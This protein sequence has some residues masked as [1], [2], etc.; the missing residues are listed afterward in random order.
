[1]VQFDDTIFELKCLLKFHKNGYS[2]EYEPEVTI[3]DKKK[4][5]DF[6]LYTEG[7]EVF[8]ECK[9]VRFEES[10]PFNRFNIQTKYISD[11]LDE[12]LKQQ[13]F[14]CKLRLEINFKRNP[15]INELKK[16][17]STLN[18]TA[19]SPNGI[20]ELPISCL[21]NIEYLITYKSNPSHF[22][23]KSVRTGLMIISDKPRGLSPNLSGPVD[24]EISIYSTDLSIKRR[25]V[26]SKRIREAKNQLP[27]ER[28]GIILLGKVNIISSSEF[29]EKRMNTSLY[30]HIFAIVLNPFEGFWACYKTPYKQILAHLFKDFQ[31]VNP[32]LQN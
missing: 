25:Q 7:F 13:L 22:P 31:N 5:P 9:Q 19:C 24:E 18:Q 4:N 26:V 1:M 2:F 10:Q 16:V 15:S 3:D 32:F 27:E 6:H 23:F 8:V 17:I 11:N 14:N 20:K 30:N 12:N 28:F 21:G 29:I